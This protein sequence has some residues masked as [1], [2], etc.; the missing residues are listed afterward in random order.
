MVR[1]PVS[2]IFG[3]WHGSG[4]TCRLLGTLGTVIG[5][6][7]LSTLAKTKGWA[8]SPIHSME[9]SVRGWLLWISI[10]FLLG[11]AVVRAMNTAGIIALRLIRQRRS[12]GIG[13]LPADPTTQPLLRAD[14]PQDDIIREHQPS[15]PLITPDENYVS[16]RSTWR[17]FLGSV[18]C[19]LICTY[20]VF[21]REIPLQMV[22]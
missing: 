20:L 8:P 3:F 18:V 13:F 1:N 2:G 19:W 4:F 22:V 10:G 6:G 14:A 21:G 15:Q 17:W 7:I 16:A 5:W 12:C 11:D 9:D